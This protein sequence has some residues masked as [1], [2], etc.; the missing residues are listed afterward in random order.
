MALYGLLK[1]E[2]V[3]GK[4]LIFTSSVD[5]AYRLKIFFD[6]FAMPSAVFNSEM[7]LECR[8]RVLNA[9]HDGLFKIL[10]ASEE[11]KVADPETAAHRGIDFSNVVAVINYDL[12][13]SV[14]NYIHR[15]GRTARGG[16]SGVVVSFVDPQNAAEA[17]LLEQVSRQKTLVDMEIPVAASSAKPAGLAA[18]GAAMPPAAA[19]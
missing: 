15:A 1:L 6:K 11:A 16:K 8:N 19:A 3:T 14:A 13:S 10:I 4:T 12:P 18:A 17:A 5:C 9:F 2:V 7:P